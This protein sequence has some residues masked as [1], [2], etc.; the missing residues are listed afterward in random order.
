[1][2]LI[3]QLHFLR[4][5][6]LLA[7]P[8]L[9]ALSLWLARRRAGEG[10]WAGLIDPELLSGLRLDDGGKPGR[11]P[12]PWL[13]LA[14]TLAALALS[15]P[16]WQRAPSVAYRGSDAWVLVLDLSPSMAVADLPPDRAT[17]AR[18]A[19]DDLLTAAHDARVGLVAFSDE[20]Y[21]VTPL[22]DDVA[23]IRALLPPLQPDIMPS[24]GDNLAPALEQAGQLL[25]RSGSK[26]GKIVVLSDGFADPAAAFAAAEKLRARGDTVDVV[27]IGT[28]TGAP[29]GK[30]GGGF[31]RNAQGQM[32]MVR[33]D[34]GR[35]KQVAASGGGRYVDL[36]GL[37]SLI[38]A[39]QARPE[40][41]SQAVEKKDIKV[42][43]W[44][45]G[46]IWLLPLLLV[47]TALLSRRGWL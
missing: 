8:L 40:P 42:Q 22:T 39:L 15:G 10:D 24:A 26:H 37:P 36:A 29:L 23:T 13:A 27:G 1:M 28:A 4:P 34:A 46:G 6:W 9:W 14:W 38:D 32:A 18:Y 11:T 17:R 31:T 7:L 47:A 20:A 3:P 16:S 25:T 2:D 12:W 21:T 5:G 30:A 44:L 33:L 35:L 19:I 41:G 43:H 45:D